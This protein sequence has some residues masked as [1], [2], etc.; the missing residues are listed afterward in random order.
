LT[1][2]DQFGRSVEFTFDPFRRHKLLNGLDDIDLT[3]EHEDEIAAFEARTRPVVD[4]T[5]LPA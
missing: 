2:T 4:T 5:R 1:I 3:L